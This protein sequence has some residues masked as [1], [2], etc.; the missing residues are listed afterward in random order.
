[1]EAER[2][3]SLK[4]IIFSL[5]QKEKKETLTEG[6]STGDE[7]ALV[8]SVNLDNVLGRRL[9]NY[10]LGIEETRLDGNCLFRAVSRM[11]YTS[12]EYHL[13]VC[14]QVLMW[15]SEHRDEFEVMNTTIP[16]IVIFRICHK[17]ITGQ[18]IR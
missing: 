3:K 11:V 12:D 13:H 9:K 1:M 14:S 8:L 16:L 6:T 4:N 10:N 18:I 17:M 5:G 15:L 7:R 2:C